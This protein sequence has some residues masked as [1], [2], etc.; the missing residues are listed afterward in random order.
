MQVPGQEYELL[1]H[2]LPMP[3]T[4]LLAKWLLQA[5]ELCLHGTEME[6]D[7]TRSSAHDHT[8][9]TPV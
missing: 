6:L 5:F 2:R 4:M 3:T 8:F 1:E 7:S 9:A